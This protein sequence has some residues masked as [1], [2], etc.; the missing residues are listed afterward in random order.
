M[1][2]IVLEMRTTDSS[3]STTLFGKTRRA[4]LS[5]LYTHADEEFYL[6][7]IARATSVGVGA[8]QR[9]LKQLTDAGIVRRTAKGNQ[10]YY[11]ANPQCP[12]YE[13]IKGLVVKTAGVGDVVR[14]ALAPLGDRVTLAF[15]YGSL[16]RGSEGRTSD[17]D[18]LLVGDIT[19]A[20]VVSTLAPAQEA[21]GRE[22]NPTVYPV[23]EFREKLAANH[24]FL[25]SILEGPKL[26]LIGDAHEL[27]GLV[28]ARLVG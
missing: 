15:I 26:F 23:S 12:V 4:V 19:F 25:K 5:L 13:E 28:Q 3:L 20:E 17:V 1:D 7:Q 22:I 24:H 9:E 21:L 16:A 8:A 2:T 18:L 10:V 27:A 11:R 14:A 6:R